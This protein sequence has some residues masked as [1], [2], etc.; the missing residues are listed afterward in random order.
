MEAHWLQ[1]HPPSQ[2][3]LRSTGRAANPESLRHF[4][5]AATRCVDGHR[6]DLLSQG[7]EFTFKIW[8]FYLPW[9][10]KYVLVKHMHK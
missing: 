6:L 10:W 9:K 3:H 7:P 5:P 2:T 1:S 4:T 8:S